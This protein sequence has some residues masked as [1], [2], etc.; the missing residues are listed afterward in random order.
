MVF[1]KYFWYL[2]PRGYQLFQIHVLVFGG[3]FI[4][5]EKQFQ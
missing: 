2:N 1:W 5:I 3:K 4:L